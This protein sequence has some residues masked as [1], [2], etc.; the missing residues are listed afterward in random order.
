[1]ILVQPDTTTRRASGPNHV[2]KDVHGG[3]KIFCLVGD[4]E[5]SNPSECPPSLVIVI[6]VQET[7][8]RIWCVHKGT[9]KDSIDGIIYARDQVQD[10]KEL[11][12]DIDPRYCSEQIDTKTA[13]R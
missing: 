6:V 4:I 3:L 1:M 5:R 13:V 2:V 12:R 8:I 11:I 10:L 7:G 9:C